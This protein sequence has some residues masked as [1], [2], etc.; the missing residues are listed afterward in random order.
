LVR[1]HFIKAYDS[2]INPASEL[3]D[4]IS[5]YNVDLVVELVGKIKTN[6]VLVQSVF[7][8]ENITPWLFISAVQELDGHYEVS[9]YLS[10]VGLL[11]EVNLVD[12]A[13]KNCLDGLN[14]STSG[15]CKQLFLETSVLT[16]QMAPSL[17][18]GGFK[19]IAE[20]SE[21]SLDLVFFKSNLNTN[22]KAQFLHLT[23]FSCQ[24]MSELFLL[25]SIDSLDC[26]EG[27]EFRNNS[28]VDVFKY[29]KIDLSFSFVAVLNNRLVGFLLISKQNNHAEISYVGVIPDFRNQGYGKCLIQK[30]LDQL[31][32]VGVTN[33]GVLVDDKNIPAR[34][35]YFKFGM[36][37]KKNWKLF[38]SKG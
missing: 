30:S 11:L 16:N 1:L 25:S 18:A 29:F 8:K 22:F 28:S 37:F 17:V 23:E 5:D 9:I 24:Q 34:Q 35:L 31:K 15:I 20:F 7:E 2:K 38:L 33:V 36:I 19:F 13:V 32:L 14:N 27:F 26:P 3:F 12:I 21:L 4:C 10:S 6:H